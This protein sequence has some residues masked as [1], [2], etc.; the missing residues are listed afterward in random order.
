MRNRNMKLFGKISSGRFKVPE[1]EENLLHSRNS[2]E[3]T[4]NPV[5]FCGKNKIHSQG[6][7]N[8]A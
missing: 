7:A 1:V 8:T 6:E 5:R 2:K 4:L 3:G